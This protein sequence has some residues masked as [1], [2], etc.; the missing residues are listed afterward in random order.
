MTTIQTNKLMKNY[1]DLILLVAGGHA[2]VLMSIIRYRN[3]N[4]S[5][6]LCP[7]YKIIDKFCG[8]PVVGDDTKLSSFDP[9]KTKVV[10]G[11]G[12]L[13]KQ[14]QRW[15]RAAEINALNFESERVI[16]PKAILADDISLGAGVQIMAGAIVQPGCIIGENVI[17]NSGAIIEHDTIIENGC[18]I[19]PGS[20]ICGG[21]KIG[22]RTHVGI[23]ANVLESRSIGAFSIVAAG[24]VIFNDLDPQ[25]NTL[26][27][28]LL[29]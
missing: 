5:A 14:E 9:N 11:I 22:S 26:E 23:G 28:M 15:I 18:H 29:K 12:A 2:K 8:V 3:M 19:A 4:V 21:V 27:S 20:T 16:H 7:D 25:T 24:H 13:P 6:V 10:N 1:N 17:I